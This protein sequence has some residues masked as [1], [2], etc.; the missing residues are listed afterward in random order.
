MKLLLISLGMFITLVAIGYTSWRL[1]ESRWYVG[2]LPASLEVSETVIVS[3]N[4][5]PREGC[6]VAIFR[7]NQ[8][9]L[10]EIQT[11]G[12]VALESARQARKD[13]SSY[14]SFSTW[15]ETPH[16]LTGDGLTLKDRWLNGI[17]CANLRAELQD[18]IDRAL[19]VRGSYYATDAE[20]GL[21]VIPGE[22]LLVYSYEG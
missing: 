19:G 6:G 1:F 5:D 9:T 12:L 8:D 16:Q 17:V 21:I 4:S 13:N 22:N 14:H 10:K 7:L 3:G 2:I 18:V 11:K 15:T 20:G